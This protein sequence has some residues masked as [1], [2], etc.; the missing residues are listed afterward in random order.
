MAKRGRGRPSDPPEIRALK[1]KYRNEIAKANA[2][3]RNIRKK[4]AEYSPAYQAWENNLGRNFS[5]GGLKSENEI[6]NEMSRVRKFLSNETSLPSVAEKFTEKLGE[7]IGRLTQGY[8]T[9]VDVAVE[10][11][12]QD[13]MKPVFEAVGKYRQERQ[14]RRNA[15]DLTSTRIFQEVQEFSEG[16]GID[17]AEM[18]SVDVERAVQQMFNIEPDEE[19]NFFD[20]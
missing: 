6:K 11:L 9:D 18:D 19:I 8:R 15:T 2:R 13:Q 1:E 10:P 3:L 12:T 7:R 4:E 14:K 20:F 16:L 5:T 17:L